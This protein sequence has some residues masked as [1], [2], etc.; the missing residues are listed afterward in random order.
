MPD[1][2]GKLWQSLSIRKIARANIQDQML[3]LNWEGRT[4]ELYLCVRSLL[5]SAGLQAQFCSPHLFMLY[6]F[7]KNRHLHSV[8]GCTPY[9]SWTGKI[10]DVSYLRVIDASEQPAKAD[11]HTAH[12]VLLGFGATPKHIGYYDLT[13]H[14]VKLIT[15][16]IIDKAHYGAS[17]CPPGTQ[18][19][20]DMG[21]EQP[22][23]NSKPGSIPLIPYPTLSICHCQMCTCQL[24]CPYLYMFLPHL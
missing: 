9:E 16:H 14:F 22:V 19:L 15:Q 17:S 24:Q 11:M 21:Y 6:T 18:V 13:S 4:S 23:P 8:L 7:K 5:Y 20:M 12:G 10:L 3:H 2:G 1:Q